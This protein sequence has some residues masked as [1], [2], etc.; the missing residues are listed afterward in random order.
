MN[1]QKKTLCI[2]GSMLLPIEI[3][4]PALIREHDGGYRCTSTVLSMDK[5]SEDEIK[6]ET[7]NTL[8]MLHL[9]PYSQKVVAV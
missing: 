2:A 3:G 6:F 8:Y 7:Q 9:T 4:E 1:Q 5:V